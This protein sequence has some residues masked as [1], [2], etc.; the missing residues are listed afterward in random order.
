MVARESDRPYPERHQEAASTQ[1]MELRYTRR[2]TLRGAP[3]ERRSSVAL[4]FTRR[5]IHFTAHFAVPSLGAHSR[6]RRTSSPRHLTSNYKQDLP[7]E[8]QDKRT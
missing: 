6:A 7:Q 1:L 2:D 4:L 3:R 8:P 5:T